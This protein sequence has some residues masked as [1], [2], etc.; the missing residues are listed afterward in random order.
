M[1]FAEA[2]S[3]AD[4]LEISSSQFQFEA[5]SDAD[6]EQDLVPVGSKRARSP[7]L[8]DPSSRPTNRARALRMESTSPPPTS[9]EADLHT[10][11]YPAYPPSGFSPPPSPPPPARPTTL[12]PVLFQPWERDFEDVRPASDLTSDVVPHRPTFVLEQIPLGLPTIDA[13]K[14]DIKDAL[15]LGVVRSA[16]DPKWN[17]PLQPC[18]S[19][20]ALKDYMI[21]VATSF[22]NTVA[23]KGPITTA[24]NRKAWLPRLVLPFYPP[25]ARTPLTPDVFASRVTS[26]AITNIGSFH[27]YFNYLLVNDPNDPPSASALVDGVAALQDLIETCMHYVIVYILI[28]SLSPH[29]P[30]VKAAKDTIYNH[31]ASI[32][33]VYAK[34]KRKR[35]TAYLT[36]FAT[37]VANAKFTPKFYVHL[38]GALTAR[39]YNSYIAAK[40]QEWTRDDYITWAPVII[41]AARLGMLAAGRP[42]RL[43]S[44][45]NM[46]MDSINR[47]RRATD[48]D[49]LATLPLSYFGNVLPSMEPEDRKQRINSVRY[50]EVRTKNTNASGDAVSEWLPLP[51][52]TLFLLRKLALMARSNGVQLVDNNANSLAF[53]Y[54]VDP[55]ETIPG[56]ADRDARVTDTVKDAIRDVCATLELENNTKYAS[57]WETLGHSR[58]VRKHANYVLRHHPSRPSTS[59]SAA[60][61]HFEEATMGHSVETG[62]L[63][64]T[65]IAGQIDDNR[66]T[67]FR[68]ARTILAASEDGP[69]L[70]LAVTS[71]ENAD[72]DIATDHIL[73]D[74]D[75]ELELEEEY[76]SST[77]TSTSTPVRANSASRNARS[78]GRASAKKQWDEHQT[79]MASILKNVWQAWEH[80]QQR[81]PNS[82]KHPTAKS[83]HLY[84]AKN[85]NDTRVMRIL[86][87]FDKKQIS[88]K[89]NNA[90]K[91]IIKDQSMEVPAAEILPE[92]WRQAIFDNM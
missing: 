43:S 77:T 23:K 10:A 36:S 89:I 63:F 1:F 38:A 11:T 60:D 85:P 30:T 24:S 58:F 19:S 35:A 79:A 33:A 83:F 64:Y 28:P 62:N 88:D 90:R 73:D 13:S 81:K 82:S 53:P 47:V 67:A 75:H 91:A 21:N 54:W 49:D 87:T 68:V 37:T 78:S 15:N 12:Q 74:E 29:V 3:D 16:D 80:D 41:H 72:T 8:L 66:I 70:R 42:A 76:L 45:T 7:N 4:D 84:A 27:L 31:L 14:E 92:Q 34:F 48:R 55:S 52:I 50:L 26:W 20:S 6:L 56:S 65:N 57:D 18:L 25:Y 46:T 86:G 40:D 59:S 51:K 71:L 2:T 32:K 5:D 22:A 44:I 9:S 17:Y 69:F 61:E 39:V